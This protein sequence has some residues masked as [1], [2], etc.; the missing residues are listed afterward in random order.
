[1]F[2]TAIIAF[3]EFLEA[4][5]IIGVFLG[6]SRKLKLK[7]EK[8]ILFAALLGIF[9]SVLL[10]ILV[11]GFGMTAR[12]IFTETNADAL[13]S[14]L[15]IFS[16]IFIAYVALSLHGMIRRG[17]GKMIIAAHTKLQQ[18]TFDVTLFFTIIFLVLREGF[19]IALFTASV[20]LFADFIQ[21]I[22]GLVIGLML[23]SGLMC[24]TYLAYLR[25]PLGKVMK[26][27][28]YMIVLLGASLIQMGVTKFFEIKLGISL[29]TIF[30]FPLSF[31]PNAETAIGH[32]VQ[33]F[34]GLD[35][36]FS[37]ARLAIMIGYIGIVLVFIFI[38]NKQKKLIVKS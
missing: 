9:L 15:L 11:Y 1:M 5:L 37:G 20:S 31:L 25:I 3:R 19:E 28:E 13:Q 26:A 24:A 38:R 36:A 16:G 22:S 10:S 27:T 6:I 23:A 32:I 17:R 7:K 14:Y 8:E 29:S 30:P 33:G 18:N 21:N 4:F 12:G 35:Q 2:P 34:F